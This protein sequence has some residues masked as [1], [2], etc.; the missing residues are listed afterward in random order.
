MSSRNSVRTEK[1][2]Q[3][4]LVRLV[5]KDPLPGGCALSQLPINPFLQPTFFLS[6]PSC[7]F[8]LLFFY[9]RVLPF[10]F[11]AGGRDGGGSLCFSVLM[12]YTDSYLT[13]L[14]DWK[15]LRAT[16]FARQSEETLPLFI[17]M[18]GQAGFWSFT[19]LEKRKMVATLSLHGKC[20]REGMGEGC[21]FICSLV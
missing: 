20:I 8:V 10:L 2:S 5:L 7:R 19:V 6:F 11:W 3:L 9:S 17:Q 4:R 15:T 13:S 1:L 14:G 18:R 21:H 12:C 16:L